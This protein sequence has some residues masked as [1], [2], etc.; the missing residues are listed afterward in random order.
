VPGK[1]VVDPRL[2]AIFR[3]GAAIEILREQGL[4]FGVGDEVVEQE[5]K[6]LG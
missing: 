5:L 2:D 1:L 6:L 4:A 3:V